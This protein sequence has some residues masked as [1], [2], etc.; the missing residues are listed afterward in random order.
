[1][2]L[3][4]VVGLSSTQYLIEVGPHEEE[5]K[6]G[7]AYTASR[8]GRVGQMLTQ[9]GPAM[10]C[11][12]GAAPLEL[13]VAEKMVAPRDLAELW[14]KSKAQAAGIVVPSMQTPRDIANK[15]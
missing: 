3:F 6:A 14:T 2:K 4:L 7:D 9:Q 13:V 1:M 5:P 11:Q 12:L 15:A 10:V 8:W